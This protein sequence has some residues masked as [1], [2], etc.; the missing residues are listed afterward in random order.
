MMIGFVCG[1]SVL[2]SSFF[3][4]EFVAEKGIASAVP[5]LI[6]EVCFSFLIGSIE[7]YS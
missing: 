1:A 7:F 3:R 6:Q 5:L 4:G 2:A